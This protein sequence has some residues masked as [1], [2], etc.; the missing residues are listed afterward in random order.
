MPSPLQAMP[1]HSGAFEHQG[2]KSMVILLKPDLAT[3][4]EMSVM[5]STCPDVTRAQS[6]VHQGHSLQRTSLP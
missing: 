5:S 1:L 4:P 6:C 2:N 3:V